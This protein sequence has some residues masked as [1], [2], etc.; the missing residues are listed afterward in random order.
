MQWLIGKT[1]KETGSYAAGLAFAGIMPLVGLVALV[2]FWETKAPD[3]PAE[4]AQ[5][6]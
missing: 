3:V 6:S 5:G 2:F 1:V 4:N